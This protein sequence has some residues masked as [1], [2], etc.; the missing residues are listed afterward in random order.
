[1]A[2]LLIDEGADVQAADNKGRTPLHQTSGEGHLEVARLLL[3]E[4][5]DVQA[6][7][8]NGRTPLHEAL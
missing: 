5:A 3:D 4:G 8:I 1:M 7:D 2:R 6:A